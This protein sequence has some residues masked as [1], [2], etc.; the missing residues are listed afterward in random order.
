MAKAS[1]IAAILGLTTRRVSQLVAEGIIPRASRGKYDLASACKSYIVHLR[2]QLDGQPTGAVDLAAER[3]RLAKVKAT[4]AE[5]GLQQLQDQLIGVDDVVTGWGEIVVATRT[6]LLGVPA[7]LRAR[8]P[9]LAAAD[10]ALVDGL[11][12][13]ALDRLADGSW[14]DDDDDAAEAEA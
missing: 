7:T 1:E 4:T 11:I 5:I 10:I 8:A 14:V 6:E 12:T 2:R 13:A 9:H 3:V